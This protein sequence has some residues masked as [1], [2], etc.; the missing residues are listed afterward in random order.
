MQGRSPA[1]YRDWVDEPKP[2]GQRRLELPHPLTFADPAGAKRLGCQFNG[3][4]T[5]MR[6]EKF[7]ALYGH[8]ASNGR[9]K[10]PMMLAQEKAKLCR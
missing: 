7:H 8:L 6:A 9:V 2:F 1:I 5:D 3:A 4:L 10:S